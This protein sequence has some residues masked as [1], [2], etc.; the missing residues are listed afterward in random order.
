PRRRAHRRRRERTASGG[1]DQGEQGDA[2]LGE[3]HEVRERRARGRRR[4]PRGNHRATASPPVRAGASSAALTRRAPGRRL[5]W[6][7]AQNMLASRAQSSVAPPKW[8]T[9]TGTARKLAMVHTPSAICP[10]TTT[11]S[12]RAKSRIRGQARAS[13]QILAELTSTTRAT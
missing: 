7:A 4:G 1:G 10:T 2:R 6:R 12:A 5:A 3:G 13:R 11:G 9:A 8:A